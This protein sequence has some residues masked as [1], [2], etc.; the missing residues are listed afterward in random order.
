MAT[1]E[2]LLA[3]SG[4][5]AS[6]FEPL[7]ERHSKALH[8][9]FARRAP[10]AADDLLA[11]AWLRAYAGRGS[12][13]AARGPVRAWLFGV[14]R[15]VLAAH[16]RGQERPAAAAALAGEASSDPW[17]AVDRRLDAAAVAPLMRRTLAELPDVER[18]L[19]L[20]IAWEQLSPTEAAAVVGVPAGTA[21]SRL[22]RARTRLRA[23]LVPSAPL[24]LTGDLA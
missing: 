1:D 16:W 3:R 5:D 7:V 2:E 14:A 13:D 18:E 24:P 22:H 19:L 4:T 15:N 6:A 12:Y 23:A 8:G 9:Y 21:R 11:E 10:G 20:L 17:H